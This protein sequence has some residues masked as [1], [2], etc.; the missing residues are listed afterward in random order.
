MRAMREYIIGHLFLVV[1]H[2]CIQRRK[3]RRELL[4]TIRMGLGDITIGIQ[5]IDSCRTVDDRFTLVDCFIKFDCVVMHRLDDISPLSFL[6]LS[7]FEL[8]VQILDTPLDSHIAFGIDVRSVRSRCSA[9]RS[10]WRLR[11]CAADKNRRCE[12]CTIVFMKLP[13]GYGL[14]YS[15]CWRP[16]ILVS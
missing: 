10:S 6:D 7:D 16:R 12:Y 5:V 15:E 14:T 9:R 1:R 8:R 4:D 2:R 11:V 13:E 3:G